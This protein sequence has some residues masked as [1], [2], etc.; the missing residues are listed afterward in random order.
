MQVEQRAAVIERF[1]GGKEKVL[2]TTNVCARGEA[3]LVKHIGTLFLVLPHCTVK[4]KK[5][6]TNKTK[7][8]GFKLDIC[9]KI[10]MGC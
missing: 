10:E 7:I 6:K 2:V 5:T 8:S 3:K 9:H 4:I 1:R